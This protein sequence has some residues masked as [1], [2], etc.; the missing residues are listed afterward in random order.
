MKRR[1]A[2]IQY[3]ASGEE[4]A[5]PTMASLARFNSDKMG[6]TIGALWNALSKGGGKYENAIC[7]IFYKNNKKPAVWE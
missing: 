5:Y 4:F 3:K 7:R 6:I 2:V 1:V